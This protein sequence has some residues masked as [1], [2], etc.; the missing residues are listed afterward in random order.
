LFYSSSN[1]SFP[2]CPSQSSSDLSSHPIYLPPYLLFNT[3][4]WLVILIYIH[5]RI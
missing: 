5:F 2:I 1:S 4:R 3:C